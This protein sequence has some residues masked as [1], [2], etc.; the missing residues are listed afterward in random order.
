MRRFTPFV[1]IIALSC[2]SIPAPVR[3]TTTA[4][5]IQMGKDDDRQV[6]AQNTV[7]TD[8]LENAWAN[9]IAQKLW[10]QAARKDIPYNLKILEDEDVNAF[11]TVG[12]YVYLNEGLLDFVQ[13]DD[14]FAGVIGHETGHIERRHVV[15]L[16]NRANVMNVIFGVASIFS[17]L[18][19]HFG[20]LAEA[21]IVAR[22]Q[23]DDELQADA[24]GLLLMSRAGYDPDAMVTFMRHL[25]TTHSQRASLV[26]KYLADHPGEPARVAHL[27]A[28][29]AL[30][31]KKRTA[32]QLLVQAQHDQEEARY[33]IAERKYAQV[34]QADP[35]DPVALLHEGEMLLA[36]GQPNKGAQTLAQAASSGPVETR[37]VALNES[38][39]LRESV[40][41]FSLTHPD[42]APLAQRVAD[43]QSAEDQQAA[44][45]AA[46]RKAA[47]DQIKALSGR[48]AALTAEAPNVG[49]ARGGRLAAIVSELNAMTRSINS[50]VAK[51]TAVVGGVGSLEKGKEG[52]VLKEDRAILAD[53]AAPLKADPLQ[54]QLIATLPYY[55]RI[56]DELRATDDDTLRAVDAARGALSLL[57]AGIGDADRALR[58][59]LRAQLDF[60]GDISAAGAR[61][62][63]PALATAVESL[64]KA[65]AAAQQ[66]SQLYNMARARDLE[67]R[68]TMLGLG[69]PEN[70]YQTLRYAIDE[71]W[72]GQSLDSNT[73]QH[74][75][76][77]PGE[78]AA[79]AVVAAD[80]NATTEAIVQQAKAERTSI[81]DVA[82]ERGM[83][84]VSLEI[85][86][87]LV[88]LDYVDDPDK[89]AH[90]QS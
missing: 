42:T 10:A 61:A 76:I 8:P 18:V 34:L 1:L 43:A 41:R 48:L 28:N 81:V 7:V 20:Q 62:A 4:Q 35:N 88:Y 45:V 75:G 13:S 26:E 69:Y 46:R 78:M 49:D 19:Y 32:D 16:N 21:G 70:R 67:V 15:T 30:D 79:A 38:S 64:D 44:S 74:D 68:I 24:Y 82:G 57:D 83:R 33:S 9:G 17:P 86:L 14:E 63:Q 5:E 29:P 40:N 52:G 77:S 60:S 66:A 37:T 89:E 54:P 22:M 73:L 53:L 36:L 25:E 39:A 80:T 84:M 12:G 11:S 55:P 27:L 65:A 87:G 51:T 58:Q 6:T 3:A 56:L 85:F 50:A 23:R 59:L 72:Q 47:Q 71:R 31:P 90:G 2:A